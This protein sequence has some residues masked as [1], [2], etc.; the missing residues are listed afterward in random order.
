MATDVPCRGFTVAPE[1]NSRGPCWD[2]TPPLRVQIHAP[3]SLLWSRNPPTMAVFPSAERET[4]DPCFAGPN[5]SEATNFGP[6]CDQTPALLVQIHEAPRLPLSELPP[7]MTVLPSA[8]MATEVPCCAAPAASEPTSFGP[9]W[10]QRLP[11]LVQIHADPWW[12]SNA[13]RS[14]PA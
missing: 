8:E 14:S 11:L 7:M 4:D 6:C 13:S 5:V 12:L 10:V 3:P 9:C 2:Q 1:P